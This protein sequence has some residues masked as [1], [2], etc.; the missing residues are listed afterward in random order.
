MNVHSS[1]VHD[2]QKA[3]AACK[4]VNSEWINQLLQ[5]AYRELFSLQ[6]NETDGLGQLNGT[7]LAQVPQHQG[8]KYRLCTVMKVNIENLMLNDRNQTEK[9]TFCVV[10]FKRTCMEMNIRD[11]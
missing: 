1:P 11:W 4:S 7:M 8:L 2:S 3:E 9:M 5:Y 10:L 6:R